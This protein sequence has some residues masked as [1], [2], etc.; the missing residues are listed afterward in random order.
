M[1]PNRYIRNAKVIGDGA[2]YT[3]LDGELIQFVARSA[4]GRLHHG[5]V[6]PVV[7]EDEWNDDL[8]RSFL[9]ADVHYEYAIPEGSRWETL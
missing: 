8:Q 6:V 7:V 9:T 4:T 1:K 3:E 5:D 2:K